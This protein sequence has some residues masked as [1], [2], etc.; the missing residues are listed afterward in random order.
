MAFKVFRGPRNT[1]LWQIVNAIWYFYVVPL[2][3]ST[4]LGG[5]M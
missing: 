2:A 1:H 5:R 4:M 3:A